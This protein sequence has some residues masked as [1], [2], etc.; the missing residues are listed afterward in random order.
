MEYG[1]DFSIDLGSLQKFPL[2]LSIDYYQKPGLDR[3]IEC[4]AKKGLH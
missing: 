2:E 1:S 3:F 4:F